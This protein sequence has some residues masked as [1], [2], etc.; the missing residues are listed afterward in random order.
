[1]MSVGIIFMDAIPVLATAAAITILPLLADAPPHISRGARM[2]HRS[3]W[4]FSKRRLLALSSSFRKR[5]PQFD[6]SLDS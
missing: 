5:Q 2:P 1:M 3:V 4:S 6:Y